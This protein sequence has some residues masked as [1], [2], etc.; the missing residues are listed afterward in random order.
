MSEPGAILDAATAEL[1]RLY[2][3]ERNARLLARK[4]AESDPWVF[5]D[6][7][8]EGYTDGKNAAA[9]LLLAALDVDR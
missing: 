9:R 6:D 7:Y 1:R 8:G 2:A 4:L 3:I 5:D